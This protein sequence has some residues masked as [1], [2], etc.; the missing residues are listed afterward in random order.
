MRPDRRPVLLLGALLAFGIAVVLAV[1]IDRVHGH[2][3]GRTTSVPANTLYQAGSLAKLPLGRRIVVADYNGLA[4]VGTNY[5]LSILGYNARWLQYGTM[6]VEQGR[7]A[8]RAVHGPPGRPER[9]SGRRCA[10]VRTVA[11]AATSGAAL[12]H[13]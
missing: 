3:T 2:S 10:V 4:A 6:G 1:A 5:T 11:A 9:P 8:H 12:H 7:Q 13:A